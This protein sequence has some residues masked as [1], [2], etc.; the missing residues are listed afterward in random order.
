VPAWA[1]V[2]EAISAGSVPGIQIGHCGRKA[3]V[4]TPWDG[5]GPLG[6]A[7]AAR[8]EPPWPVVGPSALASNPGWPVPTALSR[9]GIASIVDAFAAATRRAAAAGFR[10]IDVHGAHGYLIHSFLSPL[11][12]KRED[13]YG[14]DRPGRM[15]F[16]LEVAEAVRSEWPSHLPIFFRISAVDGLPGG[17]ELDDSVALARE[18]TR[19]GVDVIDCSSGGLGE[20]AITSPVPRAEGYQ[21]PYAARIRQ[22]AG[23]ATMAVGLIRTPAVADAA[24]ATGQADFVAI[25]REALLDPFWPLRAA[26]SLM[27]AAGYALWPRQY[28]W[29]LERRDRVPLAPAAA[30]SSPR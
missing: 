20:R 29:W 3:S 9:D 7:D 6:A 17:W 18:L 27:G 28:G 11:S 25:G 30:A 5:F 8:G 22:Q 14:G 15:R 12:N 1:A 23:I 19:R 26:V 13:G 2:A 24:I 10:A 16:A 4:Q 21:L